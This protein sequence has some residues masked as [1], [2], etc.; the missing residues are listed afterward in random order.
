MKLAFSTLCAPDWDVPTLVAR[1]KNYGYDGV[2]LTWP[3]S[4]PADVRGAFEHEGIEIACVASTISMPAGRRARVAA[5]AELRQ[6]VEAAGALGCRRV[7][8]LDTM[9]PRGAAGISAGVEMGRWLLPAADFAG[10]AGVTI[11][12][13]NALS[14]RK[15]GQVWQMLE[16]IS[17]P[18]VAACWD[19]LGALRVGESPAVSVPTLN[20]RIQYVRLRD[21]R[22]GEA[23]VPVQNLLT[24]LR[25]IGYTGYVTVETAAERLPAVLPDLRAWTSVQVAAK[26]KK[27]VAAGK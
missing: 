17:H 13:E 14:F 26:P 22:P 19:V 6:L 23:P 16:S 11:V 21:P 27:P 5:A 4:G 12:V 25:G 18:N 1:A 7:R 10:E 3:T 8:I 15:A 24:R 2:E 20:S 9:I